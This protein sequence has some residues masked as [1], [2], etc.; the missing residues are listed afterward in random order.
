MIF[1]AL[2]IAI[3]LMSIKEQKKKGHKGVCPFSWQL[4][5]KKRIKMECPFLCGKL[6]T[7]INTY[8]NCPCDVMDKKEVK[9]IFYGKIYG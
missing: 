1:S 2:D 3:C 7:K 5:G 4:E 9:T 6:F 8:S